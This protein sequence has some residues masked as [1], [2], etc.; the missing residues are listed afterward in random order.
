MGK[1][2][3]KGNC[4]WLMG[5]NKEAKRQRQQTADAADGAA[6]GGGVWR[7]PWPSAS[8][9]LAMDEAESLK[10]GLRP[11]ARLSRRKRRMR[12]GA[13]KRCVSIE[14]AV[15]TLVWLN[16]ITAGPFQKFQAN[17]YRKLFSAPRC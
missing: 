4:V 9:V 6:G 14:E 10:A 1:G 17:A 5:R 12:G 3:G 13:L 8:D 11:K 16:R 2:E 15:T 7:V